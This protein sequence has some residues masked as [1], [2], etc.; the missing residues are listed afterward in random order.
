MKKIIIAAVSD[1]NVIGKNG[2]IPWY[3]KSEL[4]HFK[5]VTLGFPVL[6]GRKTFQS[7]EKPLTNRTNLVFT[8]NKKYIS[9]SNVLVFNSIEKVYDFCKSNNFTKLF[10]I[11][12]GDLFEQM[13]NDA[14]EI[15]LSR[16]KLSVEGDTFFPVINEMY[17][18]LDNQED[19]EDFILE[20]YLRT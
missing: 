3:S 20:K 19:F 16:M 7:L 11:G 6:M 18:K 15:L 1:N 13:I 12:G 10:I 14:D 8:R 5:R 17:W 9:N 4:N 2:D